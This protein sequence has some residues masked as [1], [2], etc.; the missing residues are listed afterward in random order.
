VGEATDPPVGVV[1]LVALHDLEVL[2]L[3]LGDVIHGDLE[4]KRDWTEILPELLGAQM[5]AR[6][7]KLA[8]ERL[9]APAGELPNRPAHRLG[10]FAELS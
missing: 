9:A 8:A 3:E 4:G 10:R 1:G 5:V 2:N 7:Y 6:H